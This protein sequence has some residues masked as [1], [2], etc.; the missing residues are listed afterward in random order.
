MK[1]LSYIILLRPSQ[2][3][4]NLMLIFPPFLGGVLFQSGMIAKG[5]IPIAAFCL[6]SS[7]TY[8]LNDVLDASNDSLHPKKNSDRFPLV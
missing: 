6:A 3:L 2:W 4:K 1:I 8:I 7:A 5:I